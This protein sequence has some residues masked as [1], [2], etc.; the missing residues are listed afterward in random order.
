[1]SVRQL[2]LN[3]DNAVGQL[4]SLRLPAY[5]QENILVEGAGAYT[6]DEWSKTRA[7]GYRSAGQDS[8]ELDDDG[9]YL[10]RIFQTQY[11]N[12]LT[13]QRLGQVFDFRQY[14][15]VLELGCGEMVQAFVIKKLYPRLRYCASD[16]D[17]YI[18]EKCSRLPLLSNIEKQVLDVSVLKAE[19][20]Q[21]FQ[22]VL[23]W[24]VAYALDENNLL[25]LFG[26]LGEA[27]VSMIICTTQ[28]TGPMRAIMRWLKGIP[29]RD[30]EINRTGAR[31]HGWNHSLGYYQHL[32]RRY[33]MM[34]NKIWYPSFRGHHQDNFTFLLFAPQQ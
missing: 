4:F 6:P 15:S 13:A 7:L 17:P 9:K 23:S 27:K 30:Q 21:A 14:D 22:L 34:I 1:M 16:F 33:G 24:E 31:M 11:R 10:A 29:L 18:I 2:I 12:F 19:T 8:S 20:L 28:L 3:A 5:I 25:R 32:S 26:A